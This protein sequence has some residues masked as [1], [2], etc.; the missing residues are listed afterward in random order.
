[1]DLFKNDSDSSS[2]SSLEES[3]DMAFAGL[4]QS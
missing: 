3:Q 1:M 2:D 4:D